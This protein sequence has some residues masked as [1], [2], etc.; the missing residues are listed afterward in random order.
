MSSGSNTERAR[1]DAWKLL[2]VTTGNTSI[3]ERISIIKAMPKA[4]AQRILEC[5]VSRI[6]FETKEET[7][8]FSTAIQNNYGHAGEVYIQYIMNNL[9]AVIKLLEEVQEVVDRKA[10]LTAENRYWSV[11]ATNMTPQRSSHGL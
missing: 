3:V 7:D 2:A 8:S 6:N 9:D 1:G 11:L 5:R 4:E 10:R